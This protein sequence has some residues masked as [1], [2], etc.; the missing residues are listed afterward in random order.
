M[1]IQAVPGRIELFDGLP[2][3]LYH[4]PSKFKCQ[5]GRKNRN[6]GVLP[7]QERKKQ[8]LSILSHQ[9]I[10]RVLKENVIIFEPS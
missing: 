2:S 4:Y 1:V 3:L 6:V 8:H 9:Y 5:I 7:G 10:V